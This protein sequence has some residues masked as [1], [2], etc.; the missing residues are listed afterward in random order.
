[1]PLNLN[2]STHFLLPY[3]N[4]ASY[5]TTMAIT[6]TNLSLQAHVNVTV[7]DASGNF[8][9]SISLQPIPPG[10]QVAFAL[11]QQF[12]STAGIMGVLEVTS[13]QPMSN[14]AFRFNNATGAFTSFRIMSL[15]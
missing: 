12:P 5:A 8:L 14:V 13:D 9:N 15:N 3:D 10:G 4:T 7:R 11:T 2:G 1:M 6:N